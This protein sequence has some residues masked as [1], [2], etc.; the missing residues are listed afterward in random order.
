MVEKPLAHSFGTNNVSHDSGGADS[1]LSHT[2]DRCCV[3]CGQLCIL[4]VAGAAVG[5]SPEPQDSVSLI[6]TASVDDATKATAQAEAAAKEALDAENSAN[7]AK[8][9]E[10]DAQV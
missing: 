5:M 4:I 8:Q 9:A 6:Q 7:A 1:P 10:T 2:S 3:C